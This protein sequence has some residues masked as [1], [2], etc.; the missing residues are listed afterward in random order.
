MAEVVVEDSSLMQRAGYALFRLI[1]ARYP[2]AQNICVIAGAGNNGGDAIEVSAWLHRLGRNV[3]IIWLGSLDRM[4]ADTAQAV[5]A[6]Q[7]SGLEVQ[8]WHSPTPSS[9][10][11]LHDTL[12]VITPST[13]LIIDGLLGIGLQADRPLSTEIKQWIATINSHP[14]PVIAVDIP[15]G[16]LADT[17]SVHSHNDVYCVQADSTLTFLCAK[18]GLFTAEGRQY[19]GDIWF[20]TLDITPVGVSADDPPPQAMLYA[21]A[22]NSN[23]KPRAHNTHKG[24]FGDV[25]II[26]GAIGMTGAAI[27]AARAAITAGAGRVYTSLLSEQEQTGATTMDSVHPELMFRPWTD[28]TIES[29]TIACGCGGG[30]AV[31]SILPQLLAHCP[32]LL[33]DADALNAVASDAHLQEALANRH[34]AGFATVITPHPLEAARLLGTSAAQIQ[35]DRISTAQELAHRYQCVCV[36]KGSGTVIAEPHELPIIN[37]SGNGALA[38]AGSGDVLSGWL[39]GCWSAC[40]QAHAS[41]H[42]QQTIAHGVWEHGNAAD[43]WL[44]AGHHGVLPASQLIEWLHR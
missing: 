11:P 29:S 41:K 24:S 22:P 44:Q 32:R 28:I 25:A 3:R 7:K 18:P 15:S 6:A 43:C 10:H 8:T 27:L 2:H 14:A 39:V 36:L 1:C 38:T 17:G 30:K 20:D 40:A 16:L 12:A 37:N 42:L 19:C 33:L 5:Q 21:P 4:S 9:L 26:G 13:D 31:A 34:L 35:G 23:T